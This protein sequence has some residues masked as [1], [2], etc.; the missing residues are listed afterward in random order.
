M[1]ESKQK[2]RYVMEILRRFAIVI[3]VIVFLGSAG[4]LAYYAYE[5]IQNERSSQLTFEQ[6]VSAPNA[7]IGANHGDISVT[8]SSTSEPEEEIIQW[9]SVD[10]AALQ[11]ANPQVVGW[12]QVSGLDKISYPIVAP[13]DNY[14]Y[15]DHGWDGNY[16]RYGAIFLDEGNSGDFQDAYTLIYGHN[17]KDGSMFGGLKKY[18]NADFFAEHGGL[19]TIYVPGH[20]YVYQVFSVRHVSADA[21]SVYTM[22]FNHGETFNDYVEFMTK[23]SMYPTGHTAT[24]DDKV[25][26]LSTCAGEDRLVMHAKLVHDEV[27]DP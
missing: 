11:Q 3:C 1:E 10:F 21:S 8:T 13:N 5:S 22:G 4:Y 7:G 18:R 17:M 12:I 14:Y 24:G 26:T 16:N 23:R 15:L 6:Y 2:K 19:I 25:I 27:L 20:V 9:L